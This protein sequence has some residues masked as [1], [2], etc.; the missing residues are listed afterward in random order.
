M[1]QCIPSPT[2]KGVNSLQAFKKHFPQE[3]LALLSL[4]EEEVHWV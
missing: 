1:P 3:A 4:L 2:S